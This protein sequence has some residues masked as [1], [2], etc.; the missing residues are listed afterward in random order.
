MLTGI[1]TPA[2]APNASHPSA[3]VEAARDAAARRTARAEKLAPA[4]APGRP[5]RST[6]LA[7]VSGTTTHHAGST[8]RPDGP[9]ARSTPATKVLAR[10]LPRTFSVSLP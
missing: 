7:H 6:V 1:E 5:R 2:P 4:L 10:R 9:A 8:T 3:A